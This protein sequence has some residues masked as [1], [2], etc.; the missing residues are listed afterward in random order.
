MPLD[1][2]IHSF[3]DRVEERYGDEEISQFR[4]AQLISEKWGLSRP[5]SS[6]SRCAVTSG[7]SARSTTAG[8]ASRSPRWATSRLTRGRARHLPGEDAGLAPLRPGWE[9]TAAVASQMSVGAAALL[10]ASEAAVQGTA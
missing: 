6:S 10:V 1:K 3:G 5:I 4:G 8:S 2:G 7:R 9:V